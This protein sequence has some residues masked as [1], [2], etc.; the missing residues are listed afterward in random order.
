MDSSRSLSQ[1][2]RIFARLGQQLSATSDA[3]EAASII[4]EVADVLLGWDACYMILYDPQQGGRPRPLLAIDIVD[5]RRTKLKNIAPDRPS[6][7]MLRAIAESGF[8]KST[9][10]PVVNDPAFMFGDSSRRAESGMFVPV[11]S[12]E[13]IIGILSI[14]KY[15]PDVYTADSFQTIKLLAN[16]C[17]GALER[18]WAQEEL[19]QMAERREILYTATQAISASLD[20]EQLYEAICDAVKQ[21]MPC[22]DFVFDS[23]DESTNEIIALYVIESPRVRVHPPRY[24]ADHGLSGTIIHSGKPLLLNSLD[25]MDASGIQF[26]FTGPE[27]QDHTQSILAVPMMLHGKVKGIISAQSYTPDAY[28][29]E[30]QSLL[31]MLASH[32]AIAIENARLFSE[33]Q[34][35][36]DRD[37]LTNLLYNRRKFYEL[38]ER[39]FARV[40][41]YPEPLSVMMLDVDHFKLFNDHFGHKVGDLMLQTIAEK[42][43]QCIRS[44]DILGRHGGEEFIVM[45]PCTKLSEAA[46]IAERLRSQVEQADL[47]T[48]LNFFEMVTGLPE[49][50]DALRTTVSVG[51]AELDSTCSS[52]DVLVDHADRAMYLAKKEGR[53][54]VMAWPKAE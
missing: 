31:E 30:D 34:A 39:E 51:V 14:Q 6:P 33:M 8:I 3:E 49:N 37:P 23:Y 40:K 12:G 43:S 4:M 35:I 7:N 13:R 19:T 5:G 48:I 41:R 18:I 44:V 17:A 1:D 27:D 36:A 32:A 15:K 9:K 53:N 10:T 46:E 50:K 42:C 20:P 11:R 47:E 26:E 29:K 54:R 2:E 28:T 45:L 16:H 22:D 21:I 38:A 52:I 25:E 24:Y